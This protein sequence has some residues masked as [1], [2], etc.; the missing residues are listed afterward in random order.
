[1]FRACV[2]I[3]SPGR[4]DETVMGPL[5]SFFA[6]KTEAKMGFVVAVAGNGAHALPH[7]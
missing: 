3:W 6:K 1:M 2:W 7:L 4:Q 5:V